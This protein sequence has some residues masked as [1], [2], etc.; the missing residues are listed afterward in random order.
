MSLC[1]CAR[2]SLLIVL[3]LVTLFLSF[4]LLLCICVFRS[5]FFFVFFIGATLVPFSCFSLPLVSNLSMAIVLMKLFYV[6]TFFFSTS[7]IIVACFSL[8]LNGFLHLDKWKT[9]L[10]PW[11]G[12]RA[13]TYCSCYSYLILS[14]F[15]FCEFPLCCN[16]MYGS[17]TEYQHQQQQKNCP[18]KKWSKM[19]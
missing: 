10:F 19:K 16:S 14:H 11:Y 2:C 1:V 7:N 4:A 3:Y 12:T 8:N 5:V 9:F 18:R 15:S 17:S 6:Y 13:S